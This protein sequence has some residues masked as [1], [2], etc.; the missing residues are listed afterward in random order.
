M[1]AYKTDGQHTLTDLLAME[2]C[3]STR[4]RATLV[5]LIERYTVQPVGEY[6]GR[7]TYRLE[8]IETAFREKEIDN[9]NLPEDEEGDNLSLKNQ[10]LEEAIAIAKLD[11][12]RKEMENAKLAGDVIPKQQ[13]YE[14]LSGRNAATIAIIKRILLTQCPV[15]VSGASIAKA[16]A[17]AEG[18]YND[19]LKVLHET[20]QVF[21]REH[22]INESAF[23][24]LLNRINAKEVVSD[25]VQ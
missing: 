23:E 4:S 21:K 2:I 20:T 3:G 22:G 17:I 18:Y 15:E 6:K 10:K 25:Q 1:A 13:V 9:G 11:K 19:I 24:E 8:D 7:S 14:F 5:K 12:Q 16:R